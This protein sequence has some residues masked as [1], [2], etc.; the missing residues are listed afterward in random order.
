[1]SGPRTARGRNVANRVRDAFEKALDNMSQR[2]GGVVELSEIFEE[3]LTTDPLKVLDTVA[4]YVPKELM[5]EQ[6]VNVN[7]IK[8]DPIPIEQ[9]EQQ[10]LE[11][12]PI[13][14]ERAH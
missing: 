6:N 2:T 11:H 9:W 4:K 8:A 13:E 10:H 1:M 12:E 7:V 14:A 3:M 5:I